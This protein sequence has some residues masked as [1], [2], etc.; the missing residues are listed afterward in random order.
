MSFR[1]ISYKEMKALLDDG[2][3]KENPMM[4]EVAFQALSEMHPA[5]LLF[6]PD[7]KPILLTGLIL[8]WSGVAENW[9]MVIDREAMLK[10]SKYVVKDMLEMIDQAKNAFSLH[11]IQ[12]IVDAENERD[13]RWASFYGFEKEGLMRKYG[14]DGKDFIRMARVF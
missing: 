2:L 12:C 1:Q 13:I 6:G 8:F 5:I 4:P 3:I 10:Y 11:R 9:C 14:H 7:G